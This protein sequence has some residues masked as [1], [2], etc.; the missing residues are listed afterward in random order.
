MDLLSCFGVHS[1]AEDEHG[2]RSLKVVAFLCQ[3][4]IAVEIGS[5]A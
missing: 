5:G 3:N 2:E 1:V 4:L